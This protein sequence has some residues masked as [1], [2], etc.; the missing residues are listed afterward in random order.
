M[1]VEQFFKKYKLKIKDNIIFDPVRKKEIQITP[2]EK[3]RQKTIYFLL[4]ELGVPESQLIVEKALS[5][6]GVKGNKKRIDIGILDEF[7]NVIA[8]VECKAYFINY[9]ESPYQ[10]AIDYVSLLNTKYYFVCDG[11]DF[12]G[13][14]YE[15]ET[16]Q[17]FQLDELP[18]F[19]KIIQI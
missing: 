17:F 15:K 9:N 13:Y 16:D 2:E 3:I 6:L 12:I 1:Y 4:K 8:L 18:D 11:I 19:K 10:Q 7:G 5:S 14:K